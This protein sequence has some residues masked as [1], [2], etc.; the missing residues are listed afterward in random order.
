MA[1]GPAQIDD[2]RPGQQQTGSM[3]SGYAPA[4]GSAEA[5][6]AEDHRPAQAS[7][8]L[9]AAW[10]RAAVR[11]PEF[12]VVVCG[13][14]GGVLSG[15][16]GIY[17]ENT[18]PVGYG[19]KW[20]YSC[21]LGMGSAFI[22]VFLMANSDVSSS[23]SLRRTLAFALMCGFA[24]RPVLEAG[25]ALVKKHAR[26]DQLSEQIRAHEKDVAQVAN[27]PVAVASTTIDL[28]RKAERVDT[29]TLKAK[30]SEQA[31][32]VVNE[33]RSA[34]P[35]EPEAA[36]ALAEVAEAATDTGDQAVAREAVVAL[37]EASA[38]NPALARRIS[39]RLERIAIAADAKKMPVVAAKSREALR[40]SRTA[41]PDAAAPDA[42][43]P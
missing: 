39:P 17:V 10:W 2:G 21:L 33:L 35:N 15:V 30:A 7:S 28:L 5:G 3:E 8:T 41:L 22:G 16:Y 23:N 18:S 37:T 31:V 42:S 27:A 36:E 12:W 26:D 40:G 32:K 24:W 13:A 14:A 6:G 29:E 38:K 11:R 19:L 20:L 25:T 43:T 9:R 1:S 34:A 4:T